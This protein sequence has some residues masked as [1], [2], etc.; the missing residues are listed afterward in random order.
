MKA[1]AD[2]C[3]IGVWNGKH[4]GLLVP[5]GTALVLALVR[6]IQ[7]RFRSILLRFRRTANQRGC[8]GMD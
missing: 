3:A 1:D 7:L 6:L 2:N 5:D 8:S 4:D